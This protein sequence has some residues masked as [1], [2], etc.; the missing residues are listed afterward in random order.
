MDDELL[1]EVSPGQLYQWLQ[2]KPDLLLLDVR[3]YN[4]V[5][6]AFI[7]DPRV[8]IMPL[9]RLAREGGAALPEAFYNAPGEVVVFCHVGE[10]SAQVTAWLRSQGYRQVYN[11]AGGIDAYSQ[12]IDGTIPRY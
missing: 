1:V 4:E 8:H 10:R 5:A 2:S 7:A 12:A 3:E 11:L 9:S 6:Y